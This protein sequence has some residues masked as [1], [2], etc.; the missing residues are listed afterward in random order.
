[1]NSF[2]LII[3]VIILAGGLLGIYAGFFRAFSSLSGFYLSALL[4]KWTVPY[5]VVGITTYTPI[6]DIIRDW[7]SSKIQLQQLQTP[8][9]LWMQEPEVKALLMQQNL[10]G[11]DRM[12]YESLSLIELIVTSMLLAVCSMI[13]FISFKLLSQYV[14]ALAEDSAKKIP[15]FRNFNKI[16]GA[17][18]GIVTAGLLATILT[19]MWI[20][21]SMA[22]NL[23]K[24]T[25]LDTTDSWVANQGIPLLQ[26]DDSLALKATSQWLIPLITKNSATRDG[27]PHEIINNPSQ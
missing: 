18:M 11:I 22:S 21:V 23:G 24:N 16:G 15:L 6:D 4:T 5:V 1:M 14:F 3:L 20:P 12:V 25:V 26:L 13:L 10:D 7:L 9:S 2:D 8:Y 17:I 19:V 27:L